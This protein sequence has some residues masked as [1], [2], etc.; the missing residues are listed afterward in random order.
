MS[1]IPWQ[2]PVARYAIFIHDQRLI[3]GIMRR[4]LAGENPACF[5]RASSSRG[6]Y[7]CRGGCFGYD[8]ISRGASWVEN[9]TEWKI[10]SSALQC[11]YKIWY[12]VFT[13]CFPTIDFH[14]W[15][16]KC[17][18]MYF[19][20][21]WGT[22]NERVTVGEDSRLCDISFWMASGVGHFSSPNERKKNKTKLA[23]DAYKRPFPNGA[24]S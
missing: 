16:K 24:M 23:S 6:S 14:T 9:C 13:V 22:K 20:F 18:K 12:T 8:F 21:V 2:N 4:S 19:L 3:C 17:K 10:S 11:A 7:L 5:V 15:G 1:Q